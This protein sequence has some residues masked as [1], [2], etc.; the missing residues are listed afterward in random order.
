MKVIGEKYVY[1]NG[2]KNYFYTCQK[3]GSHKVVQVQ[4]GGF[5]P[6]DLVCE[7][8]NNANVINTP[9][10]FEFYIQRS[11]HVDKDQPPIIITDR[12]GT[13]IEINKQVAYNLSGDVAI[14]IIKE[15]KNNSWKKSKWGWNLNF[16]LTI[17][18]E[19]GRISK[20]KNPNAFVII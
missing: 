4:I 1:D 7:D 5:Q 2:F 8:C 17:E 3:C 6:P 20:V 14:G 9:T 16:E 11:V 13:F 12:R 15:L 10:T 18:N 19:D